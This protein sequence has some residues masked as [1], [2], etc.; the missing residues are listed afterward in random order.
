M[1]DTGIREQRA[2]AA[3]LGPSAVLRKAR[4]QNMGGGYEILVSR[5]APARTRQTHGTDS[6]EW[7]QLAERRRELERLTRGG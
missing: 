4:R 7:A 6:D 1:T 5:P 2:Q 3:A